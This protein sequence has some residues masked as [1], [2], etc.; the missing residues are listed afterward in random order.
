MTHQDPHHKD[1][2]GGD[3]FSQQLD[4]AGRGTIQTGHCPR[5]SDEG[6]GN[7]SFI[8]RV[9]N[10]GHLPQRNKVTAEWQGGS[11]GRYEV[12]SEAD[13]ARLGELPKEVRDRFEETLKALAGQVSLRPFDHKQPFYRRAGFK[14]LSM[15][16]WVLY[17]YVGL[18]LV[19][20]TMFNLIVLGVLVAYF[21]KLL[22]FL[23]AVELRQEQ[24]FRS[25]PFKRFIN[26][27]NEDVFKGLQLAPGTTGFYTLVGT[28]SGRCIELQLP[29]DESADHGTASVK[30]PTDTRQSINDPSLHQNN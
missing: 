2:G 7:K 6:P 16:V 18:L 10:R 21:L 19:T 25:R 30:E 11:P 1:L 17:V 15:V 27:Q 3:A 8:E 5:D 9:L 13:R 24:T 26:E 20:L 23:E 28:D 4:P 14:V 22:Y 12:L 29:Q